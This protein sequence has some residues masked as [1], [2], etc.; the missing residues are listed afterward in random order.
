MTTTQLSPLGKK[1]KAMLREKGWT[2]R[3]LARR[4]GL[5]E[6]HVS[7]ILRA[8]WVSVPTAKKLAL[9]LSCE[10]EEFEA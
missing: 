7:E 4:A 5:R 6:S 10:P 9:A 1:I 3:K 2:Q 8:A